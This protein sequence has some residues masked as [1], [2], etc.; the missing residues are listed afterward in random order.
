MPSRIIFVNIY[1]YSTFIAGHGASP[2]S[3]RSFGTA[4]YSSIYIFS[5]GVGVWVFLERS[6]GVSLLVHF[7]TR[8]SVGGVCSRWSYVLGTSAIGDLRTGEKI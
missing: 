5:G 6:A 3:Y 7:G 8:G 4:V 1:I 2:G